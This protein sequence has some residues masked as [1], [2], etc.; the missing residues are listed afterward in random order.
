MK[1][2]RFINLKAVGWMLFLVAALSACREDDAGTPQAKMRTISLNFPAIQP[3]TASRADNNVSAIEGESTFHTADIWVFDSNQ[4]GEDVKA[5]AYKH[6]EDAER[7]T[8]N[9]GELRTELTIPREI[10][11]VDIY[12]ITN[13]SAQDL[14]ANS[15][16]T[17]LQAATFKE[18]LDN[19]TSPELAS[20]GL[21]MSRIITGI[22][23][24]QLSGG[25]DASTQLPLERGV[26][27]IACFFAKESESTQAEIT[28]ITVSGATDRGSVFPEDVTFENKDTRPSAANVPAGVTNTET[29]PITPPSAIQVL[30]EDATLARGDEEDAQNYVTRLNQ[31]ASST[32]DYYLFE[33]DATDMT[34]TIQYTLGTEEVK[35]A[36]VEL[37]KDVIRNHYVVITGTVKGGILKLEYLALQWK[38]ANSAIGWNA[39]FKIAAWNSDDY[40]APN[41]TD[42][43]VGDEEA[44]YCYVVYPR[45]EDNNDGDK[46]D[47]DGLTNKPSYA[48]FYFQLTEPKG[49]VWK[50]YL[51]EPNGNQNFRFG[52]GQYRLEENGPYE[53]FCVSTGIAREE[54][55]QIQITAKNAWTNTDFE[56]LINTPWGNQ[57]ENT[58]VYADFYIMISLDGVEEYPLEINA[59]DESITASHWLGKR[60]FAGGKNEYIR[61]W[62]LKAQESKGFDELIENLPT[63]HS[64]KQYW[65][66][67]GSNN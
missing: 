60:R 42:A 2:N 20:K 59:P 4:T 44:A 46:D 31:I 41:L 47:H 26:A 48:G 50:A 62:Q 6:I 33:A 67:N 35:T 34:V 28:G 45:Y 40:D 9:T 29:V 63:T 18:K 16:R 36:T 49:A 53:R 11:N 17:V 39:Q 65:Q 51:R 12:V 54:P 52:T 38:N 32:N 3:Y 10:T 64:I 55:Y 66:S 37:D 22:P 27:K 24:D 14:N 8:T 13:N 1:R 58:E 30:A 25:Y 15:T 7:Y 19:E 57:V 5:A 23:V 21:L 56:N 61:I 43:K